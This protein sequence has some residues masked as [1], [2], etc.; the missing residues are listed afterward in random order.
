MTS[1]G[2]A[3]QSGQ[4]HPGG[5]Q[6]IDGLRAGLRVPQRA[7]QVQREDRGHPVVAKPLRGLIA[8]YEAYL[9]RIPPHCG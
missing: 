6:M 3:S 9:S 5:E 1:S 7:M 4:I 2:F 8:D